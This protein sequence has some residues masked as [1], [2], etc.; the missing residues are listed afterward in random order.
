VIRLWKDGLRHPLGFL[1]KSSGRCD[2]IGH[3]KL[4]CLFRVLLRGISDRPAFPGQ[5]RKAV[6]LESKY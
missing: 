3:D 6:S 1:G 5:L 4:H 2:S